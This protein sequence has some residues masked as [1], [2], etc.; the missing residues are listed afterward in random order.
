MTTTPASTRSR[1]T[2]SRLRFGGVTRDQRRLVR[3]RRRRAVRHHRAQR[4]RQDV[5]L[6][7]DQP[8]VPARSRATSAGRAQSIMGLRPDKVAELGIARTFQ[9][10]ELFPQMTVI[11]NLLTGRHVRMK[12]S[13]LAGRGVVRA[14]QAARR[15][16]TGDKV[17]DI[18]DFLEIEQWRKHPVG[19]AA[20]RLPEAGRAR[21]GA[22]DGARAAAARRAGGRHE[23]RGDRGHGPL[24][25][26]HPATSSA[27][28]WSSSSTTW[29]W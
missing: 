10:I 27:S 20:L 17:E 16:R 4:R 29:A 5:D 9:N 3:R 12:R 28:P 1:S 15:W 25:P 2:T 22:G 14:G 19:A 23:P 24:H 26:R 8:G 18:I 11:D 6:Q 7:L 13:W 21:P